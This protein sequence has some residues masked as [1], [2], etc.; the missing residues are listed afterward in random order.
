MI[1]AD[2]IIP[3]LEASSKKKAFRAIAEEVAVQIGGHADDLLGALLDRE[4]I[5]T[6]GIGQGVAI[7]HIKIAG[8]ERMYGVL[9]RLETPVDYDA[10]DNL[11]VDIIFMLLAPAESKTTQHLK[12]LAHISRFLKDA[13]TCDAIRAAR[14]TESLTAILTEWANSQAA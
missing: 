12:M 6:T 14:E 2:L 3:A 11:P 1:T 5:G 8:A 7:P 13:K 4:R 9:V 10:I